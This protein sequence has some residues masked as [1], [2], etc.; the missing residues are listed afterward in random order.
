MSINL[1]TSRRWSTV[2]SYPKPRV[3]D[4][5]IE[6]A[7]RWRD[8]EQIKHADPEPSMRWLVEIVFLIYVVFMIAAVVVAARDAAAARKPHPSTPAVHAR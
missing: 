1:P 5:R 2:G 7:L 4:R 8:R 6:F 3:T